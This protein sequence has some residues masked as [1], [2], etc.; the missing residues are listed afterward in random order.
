MAT[1]SKDIAPTEAEL[2]QRAA[3]LGPTLAERRLSTADARK[4][5]ENTIADLV[6]AG[7]LKASLPLRFGGYELPFGAHTNIA[8]ELGRYCGATAWVAGILG[9]HNWWLGKYHPE[10]QEEI[11]GERSGRPGSSRLRLQERANQSGRRWLSHFRRMA[12][13]QWHR[14][15][16]LGH[17]GRPVSERTGRGAGHDPAKA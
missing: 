12:F 3:A 2:V 11:W 15:L 6:D 4:L 14:Q 13:L 9:S 7:L 17:L 16:R 10:T 5:P 1:Q 8:A